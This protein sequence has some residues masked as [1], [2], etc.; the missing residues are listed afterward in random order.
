MNHLGHLRD[1]KQNVYY[2]RH[3]LRLMRSPVF[4]LMAYN[5]V[6]HNW[7]RELSISETG[8]HGEVTKILQKVEEL[9]SCY[10][11]EINLRR[12]YIPKKNGKWRPLG[13]PTK[14]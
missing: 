13:V 1:R 5:F 11:T 14:A 8:E 10:E 7:H 4:Q 6:C 2:W 9:V 3:A 12:V